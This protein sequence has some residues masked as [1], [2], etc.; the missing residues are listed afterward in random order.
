MCFNLT[1]VFISKR[2]NSVLLSEKTLRNMKL[3]VITNDYCNFFKFS[4]KKSK[5]SF[6]QSNVNSCLNLTNNE[7]NHYC[8]WEPYGDRQIGDTEIGINAQVA[9]HLIGMFIFDLKISKFCKDEYFPCF[10]LECE[11]YVIFT[12]WIHEEIV[13]DTNI[14]YIQFQILS[15]LIHT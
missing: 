14:F 9:K 10:V 7:I 3:N 11:S 5:I 12:T 6:F 2:T 13:S 15:K 1:V 4:S 8:S